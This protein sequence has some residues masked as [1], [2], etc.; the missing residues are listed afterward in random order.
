MREFFR[1][2]R[3]KVGCVTLVIVNA[4]AGC[5][6][7]LT[8]T[9]STTYSV[10]SSSPGP[11]IVTAW[12]GMPSLVNPGVGIVY[13]SQE[14]DGGTFYPRQDHIPGKVVIV[15]H[16]QTDRTKYWREDKPKEVF[17]QEVK[18]AG[19]IPKGERGRTVFNIDKNGNWTV[20]FVPDS[21]VD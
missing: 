5:S 12:D 16:L 6:D 20:R 19:V 10:T 21:S 17:R 11:V 9:Y 14:I 3:R 7:S 18:M 8:S 13:P 1:G 2:W 4:V 15:W